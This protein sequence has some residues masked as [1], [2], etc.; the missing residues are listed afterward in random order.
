MAWVVDTCVLIDVISEDARFGEA[1]ADCLMH[2]SKKGLVV[3]PVSYVE[4]APSFYGD[5]HG[6]DSFLSEVEVD[7][8]FPWEWA[9]TLAAH[10]AWS[11]YVDLK[12]KKK[13]GRRPIAD[14]Q[15]GAFSLRFDGLITRNGN[16]FEKLFPKL[17]LIDPTQPI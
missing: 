10:M 13:M 8:T 15:I 1:S 9:D 14:I 2:Y 16:D 17:K 3:T 7:Y 4:M 6:Q 12:R 11:R 5:R